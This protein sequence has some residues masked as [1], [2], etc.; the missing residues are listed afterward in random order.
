ME[1]VIIISSHRPKLPMRKI[2]RPYKTPEKSDL[3]YHP[4]KKMI[5]INSHHGIIIRKSVSPLIDL[6]VMKNIKSNKTSKLLA[7][8][9]TNSSTYFPASNV[10]SGN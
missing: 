5:T 10:M 4:S 1:I 9:L 3:K 8:K 6:E 2:K 7:R